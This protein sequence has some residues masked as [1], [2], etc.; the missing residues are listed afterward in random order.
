MQSQW[1]IFFEIQFP[2]P[3]SMTYSGIY[4]I[5]W[6]SLLPKISTKLIDKRHYRFYIYRYLPVAFPRTTF[7]FRCKDFSTSSPFPVLLFYQF[8]FFAIT[9]IVFLI[10][11]TNKNCKLSDWG[12]KTIC[13]F[14]EPF[15][16]ICRFKA[17]LYE[18]NSKERKSRTITKNLLPFFM[19]YKVAVIWKAKSVSLFATGCKSSMISADLI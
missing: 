18:E 15:T 2:F 13:D 10:I 16:I 14:L 7:P 6:S 12:V 9:T 19:H 4:Q 17:D 11:S 8:T 5:C 3:L 1:P